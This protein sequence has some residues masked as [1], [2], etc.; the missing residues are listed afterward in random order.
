MVY[1]SCWGSFRGNRDDSCIDTQFLFC[2]QKVNTNNKLFCITRKIVRF[3]TVVNTSLD[4]V[5]LRIA[6]Q[7]K[8]TRH[9]IFKRNKIIPVEKKK[10]RYV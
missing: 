9:R 10:H 8:R 7:Q 4:I 3:G 1:R 2:S 5:L 6:T